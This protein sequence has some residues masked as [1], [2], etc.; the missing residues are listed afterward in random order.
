[1]PANLCYNRGDMETDN[2]NKAQKEA[3]TCK[4]GPLVIVAGAGTGKTTVIT[5]RIA[6]LIEEGL[7]KSDEILALTF[8]DK[9]ANEMEERV[10]RLLPYG[11]VDLWISTFHSFCQR[12]L[13]S[14]GMEI[15]LSNSMKLL[16]QTQQWV[17]V[18]NNFSRFALDYYR[19]LGN[20]T[21]FLHAMLRHFSRL[22]DEA[23]TPEEYCGY[24]EDL[25]LNSDSP[26]FISQILGEKERKE[27]SEDEIHEYKAQEIKK[28]EE[29]SRAYHTYQELLLENGALDFGD[30]INYC[31]MLFQKRPGV[32]AKMRSQFRYILVDEFQD[33]NWAQYE[34][35]KLLSFPKNNLTVCGD[36]DQSIYKFRGASISNILQFQKDFPS[37]KQVFLVENYRT[38]QNI[39]DLAY[40]FI[41]NN[42][43]NRLEAALADGKRFSKK[44]ISKRDKEGEI[45]Y[46]EL[47]TQEDE[48]RYVVNSILAL[49]ESDRNISWSDFAILVRANSHAEIFNFG[50]S[51][52]KVP[53]QFF[54]SRGLYNKPIVLDVLSW[55]RLL[56]NYHESPSLFHILTLDVF[57]FTQKEL[58][59]LNYWSKRKGRSLYGA[60][61]SIQTLEGSTEEMVKKARRVLALIEK[62][63]ALSREKTVQ[64]MV[65]LFLEESGHLKEITRVEDL[66][67]QET[68]SHLN[69]FYKKITDFEA[70]AAKPSVKNFLHMM[71]ME[72]ESGEEGVL[73]NGTGEEGPE[74]VKVMTIHAAKG[75]E[76]RFVFVVNLVDRRFPSTE[77]KEPIEIPDALVRESLPEGNIHL[78]EE[79]RL[80]YVACT[81]AK[82]GLW[83]T[84]AKNYGG[85]RTK[86]PSIFIQE[87]E[88]LNLDNQAEERSSELVRLK[89]ETRGIKEKH[90]LPSR[91][92]F[93]QLKAYENCPWQYRYAFILRV[94]VKGKHVFSFGKSI[95]A[96]MQRIFERLRLHEDAV[97]GELFSAQERKKKTAGEII[98]FEEVL[99]LYDECFIDDW[100]PTEEM[101]KEYNKKGKAILRELYDDIKDKEMHPVALEK[102]FVIKIPDDTRGLEYSLYGVIDRVD[103]ING[104]LEIIDY[105]TGKAK[106]NLKS[107]DKEQLLIYQLAGRE[108]FEKP[109]AKL[110]F[111]YVE[112]NS[113]QSFLGKEKDLE[114]LKGKIISVIHE[115]ETGEFPP[116]P[117]PICKN[118]D[119]RDICPY[120]KI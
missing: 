109:V 48:M 99:S 14:H 54:A 70:G 55:L 115:I 104:N 107:D 81:R 68:V 65:M 19:P 61:S 50:L 89:S 5:K 30:L 56:D 110:T 90:V 77:K 53:Y 23:I 11:H 20:P 103:E 44:L 83:L 91:F 22:K 93:S 41:Q 101:M 59:H 88:N 94:P 111:H 108:I 49:K 116:K 47:D 57:G 32:L 62:H 39:L 78:E 120:K 16:N 118:C 27:L 97:Q 80:F 96:V 114:K 12:I 73:E 37:S 106:D 74:T 98:S 4:N 6:W 9:A 2:L 3:V 46:A 33:T 102:G 87:L 17:L 40:G 28:I 34:L 113:K 112:G 71:E 82:D 21:K 84:G 79:R 60:L 67:T 76:F 36:D 69:Q 24:A 43:P 86:K 51:Q 1:M 13:E 15:G 18:Y 35:V 95:H 29:I 64:E 63:T 38:K 75:L 58:V 7:A 31:L 119:F 26:N 8:T 42:N 25:K 10:D 72:I 105:K 52:A 45:R 92:S 100:Y 117:G 85:S 66:K